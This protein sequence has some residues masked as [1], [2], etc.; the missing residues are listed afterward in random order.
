[1]DVL[2]AAL[3]I[4]SYAASEEH[5]RRTDLNRQPTVTVTHCLRP[6]EVLAHAKTTD[7]ER[8]GNDVLYH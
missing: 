7:K 4:L 8:T 2:T 1:M 3:S 5:L 6:A